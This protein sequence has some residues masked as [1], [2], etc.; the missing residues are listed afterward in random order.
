MLYI[1]L[2]PRKENCCQYKFKT[3][4]M[5]ACFYH[6]VV[7]DDNSVKW[8]ISTFMAYVINTGVKSY[9]QALLS[10]NSHPLS[11]HCSIAGYKPTHA[12][13]I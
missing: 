2:G 13:H 3:V 5:E 8:G 10:I 4:A 9:F 1:L 12:R 6:W 11:I 7:S